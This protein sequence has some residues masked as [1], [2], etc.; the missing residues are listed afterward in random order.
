MICYF[1]EQVRPGGMTLAERVAVGICAG[2][3]AGVCPEHSQKEKA[4]GSPLLCFECAKL[5]NAQEKPA[6]HALPVE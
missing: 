4:P 1:C 6:L 3:G 5:R 2:C